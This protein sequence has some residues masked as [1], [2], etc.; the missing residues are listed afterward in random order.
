MDDSA[1]GA[2]FWQGMSYG[3]SLAQWFSTGGARTLSRG[4]ASRL[5]DGRKKKTGKKKFAIFFYH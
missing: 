2:I 1:E 4:G 5:Q 3:D